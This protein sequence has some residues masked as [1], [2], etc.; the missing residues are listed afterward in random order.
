[1][2][3]VI[4][5]D[6]NI[7]LKEGKGNPVLLQSMIDAIKNGEKLYDA[8]QKYIDSLI[9][10]KSASKGKTINELKKSV[11]YHPDDKREINN[12]FDQLDSNEKVLLVAKQSRIRPGGALTSPNTVFAT[13]RRLIIRNP[14]MFGMRESIEDIPYDQITSVKIERGLFS[15]TIVIRSP[16]LSELSRLSSSSGLLAWGREED[17]AIDSLE[18]D[19][20]EQILLII[21]KGM[22]EARKRKQQPT[23]TKVNKQ[24][25][26]ADE[27]KKLAKLKDQ[28][29][30]SEEEFTK[31]KN[32]L[33]N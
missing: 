13:D 23:T 30:I 28:G 15:S 7:L 29:V 12:I 16:G 10:E 21:K 17:G 9:Y 24:L 3:D 4:V 26:V 20:A 8:D 31:M 6:I 11:G 2:A 14:T 33:I 1:L 22:A 27:L 19:K 18:K 32:D 25:S 5:D